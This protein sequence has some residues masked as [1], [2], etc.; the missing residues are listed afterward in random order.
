MINTTST[1][2]QGARAYNGQYAIELNNISKI[3]RT[4]KGNVSAVSNVSFGIEPARAVCLVGESGCGKTTTG[5]MIAGLTTPTSGELLFEGKNIWKMNKA[6]FEHYRRAVQIIHQDPYASL[7]PSR[8]VYQILSAPLERHKIAKGRYG[9]QD[10]VIELLNRVDLTP[11]EDIITKFPHQLSGGQRQRLSVARALTVNPS[12]IVADE[13]VSMLD[14]SIRMSL[15]QTLIKLRN[16]LGVGFAFITH[17]LA[18]AKY[19]AWAGKIG[20]MYLGRLVEFG[21]TPEVIGNPQHPYTQALLGAI[22]EAD[23]DITRNKE[24]IKLRSLDIPS[25]YNIPSG[26]SFHPRCPLFEQGLCDVIVPPLY[27][28]KPDHLAACH[29]T[30]R[31]VAG[32]DVGRG[33]PIAERAEAS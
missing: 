12:F 14:V 6:E 7:N 20:V 22:P 9:L 27:P 18:V 19:F 26:C 15:L 29:V 21:P 1:N 3:F 11:A 8:S 2:G 10:K 23:P 5:K 25:L 31:D 24:R 17:D 30:A 4:P 33:I 28:I 13:A 32:I 16:E